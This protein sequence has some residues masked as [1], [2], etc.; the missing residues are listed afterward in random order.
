[1]VENFLTNPNLS[2]AR[3]ETGTTGLSPDQIQL[4]QNE[5]VCQQL[6]SEYGQY[7]DYTATYHKAGNYYFATLLLEQPDDPQQVVSGISII[8]VLNDELEKIESY[9]G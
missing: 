4:V 7:P 8:V 2:G 6:N 9:G 5:S 3:Q 1:M